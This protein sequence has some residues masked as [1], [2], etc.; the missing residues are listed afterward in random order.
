MHD[1]DQTSQFHG[2]MQPTLYLLSW[3][4]HTDFRAQVT[5]AKEVNGYVQVCSWCQKL[6]SQGQVYVPH[7]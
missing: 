2:Q 1:L 5:Q 7:Y 3:P 6:N 4:L